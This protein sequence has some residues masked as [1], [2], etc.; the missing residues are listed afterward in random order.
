MLGFMRKLEPWTR[1]SMAQDLL[2]GRPLELE[3]LNGTVVRMGRAR[4]VPVPVNWC[5]YAAL[6]PF[7]HGAPDTPRPSHSGSVSAQGPR[8]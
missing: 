5:I 7:A 1:G 3:T 6:R 8:R 4:N 2:E